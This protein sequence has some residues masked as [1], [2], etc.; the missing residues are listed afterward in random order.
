V[1]DND[2]LVDTQL[3][4][5]LHELRDVQAPDTL[6]SRVLA[7]LGL[8]DSY[9]PLDTPIGRVFVAYNQRGISAVM[10]AADEAEFETVFRQEHGRPTLP[11]PETPEELVKAVRA[12]L[13]GSKTDL[14]FD[15]RGLT[16]FER[17]VLL[18]ALEIPRGQIRSYSWIAR[19]IGRPRAVRAVGSAL[20]GNPIPLLIPCH[21]VVRNDGVIGNYGLGG[22]ENKRRLLQAEG[23]LLPGIA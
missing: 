2:R 4:A 3:L 10:A 21:R 6:A 5:G 13:S 14:R 19:E 8:A 7:T 11:A 23:S 15:L 1:N 12:H 9:M 20:A 16:E 18:K 17:A 22:P